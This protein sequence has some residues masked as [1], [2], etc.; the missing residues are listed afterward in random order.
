[1]DSFLGIN[2]AIA[3][4]AVIL[5]CYIELEHSIENSFPP[6]VDN[7]PIIGNLSDMSNGV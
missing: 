3:G 2:S 1:M 4:A 6:V 7:G 5:V